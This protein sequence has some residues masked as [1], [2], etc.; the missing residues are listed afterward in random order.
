MFSTLFRSVIND[1]FGLSHFNFEVDGVNYHI[2]RTGCFPFIKYHSSKRP[3]QDLSAENT[4]FT[5][6]KIINLGKLKGYNTL[7]ESQVQCCD[8]FSCSFQL[9]IKFIML[10]NIE[11]PTIFGILV[12]INKIKLR[13]Y[14]QAP[15]IYILSQMTFKK[16][17]LLDS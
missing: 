15:T 1:H 9:G 11:M 16:N 6:L 10:I 5:C 12:F 13:Q 3:Y 14:Y 7:K 4:F 2:L 17:L 8:C